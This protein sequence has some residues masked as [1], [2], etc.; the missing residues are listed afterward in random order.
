MVT[1]KSI[2]F[3]VWILLCGKNRQI[4]SRE[5]LRSFIWMV[6]HWY[7]IHRPVVTTEYNTETGTT[8]KCC[9]FEWPHTRVLSTDPKLEHLRAENKRYHV[10]LLLNSFYLNSCTPRFH[11]LTLKIEQPCTASIK[12]SDESAVKNPL[13]HVGVK[14]LESVISVW[15]LCWTN[16]NGIVARWSK[17]FLYDGS[18]KKP[19]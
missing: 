19:T 6:T 9:S 16:S 5:V 14:G 10:K 11:L 12:A 3:K 18:V 15:V 1:F 8:R 13:I 4:L 17:I 7:F 2:N